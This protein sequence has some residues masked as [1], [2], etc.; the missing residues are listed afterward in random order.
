MLCC[1]QRTD[2]TIKAAIN[3]TVDETVLPHRPRERAKLARETG[4]LPN[5]VFQL[6]LLGPGFRRSHLV[7]DPL[8]VRATE[9][10]LAGKGAGVVLSKQGAL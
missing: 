8:L 6:A 7:G 1:D 4:H 2:V 3:P 5:V 10:R 9:S